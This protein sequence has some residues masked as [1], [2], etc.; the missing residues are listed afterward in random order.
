MHE[1]GFG[2]WICFFQYLF[3]VFQRLLYHPCG[4]YAGGFTTLDSLIV[5]TITGSV[6]VSLLLTAIGVS[7][8]GLAPPEL[9]YLPVVLLSGGK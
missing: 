7:R 9:Q 4:W 6:A 5:V 2:L 8:S 3:Y 1:R